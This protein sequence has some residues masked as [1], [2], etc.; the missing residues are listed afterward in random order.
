MTKEPSAYELK[1]SWGLPAH[2]KMLGW[3]IHDP[4]K[5]EFLVKYA[6]NHD[7]TGMWWGM[8]PETAKAFKTLK[9]AIAVIQSLELTGR[10]IAAPAFDIGRQ[11][12]VLT[13]DLGVENPIRELTRL[14]QDEASHGV[15]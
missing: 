6:L 4:H 14:T 2:A 7:M 5:D 15:E 10:A 3:L 9:K 1:Q 11:I 8:S 13:E 12:M